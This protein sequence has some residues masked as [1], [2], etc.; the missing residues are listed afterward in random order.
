MSP[1][2]VVA[3]IEGVA[4]L[5]LLGVV[6]WLLNRVVTLHEQH[7]THDRRRARDWNRGRTDV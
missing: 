6:D 7:A 4:I 1:L 5:V 2:A 3:T